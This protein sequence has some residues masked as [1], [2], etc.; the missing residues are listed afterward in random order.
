M[1]IENLQKYIPNLH[2]YHLLNDGNGIG[3]F[4]LDYIVANIRMITTDSS[5]GIVLY[6]GENGKVIKDIGL[7]KF[8]IMFCKAYTCRVE[9]L[10]NK[11]IDDLKIDL[12]EPGGLE[13][14]RMYTNI[15]T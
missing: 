6:K 12:S 2:I 5:R 9:D 10:M 3:R 15:I 1:S 13:Q 4:V 8:F 11:F 14:H 7:N